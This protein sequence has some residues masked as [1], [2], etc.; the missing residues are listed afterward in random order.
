M[1]IARAL[2]A[3]RN[4][5]TSPPNVRPLAAGSA[6]EAYR[7]ARA[8]GVS[9]LV[10]AARSASSEP[11]GVLGSIDH[12]PQCSFWSSAPGL[13]NKLL[14]PY[15]GRTYPSDSYTTVMLCE[16]I[17]QNGW[18]RFGVLHSNDAYAN[19]YVE[20]LRTNAGAVGLSIEVQA[21]YEIQVE[22]SYS[23]AIQLIGNSR[24]NILVAVVWNQDLL[25]LAG[26]A[27]AQ[28]IWGMGFVWIATETVSPASTLQYM[29]D[30]GLDSNAASVLLDGV[31]VF[32]ASPQG[33]PG[34]ARFSNT[35]QA[36]NLTICSNPF[37]SASDSLLSTELWDVGA[38]AYD[39]VVAFAVSMANAQD[40]GDGIELSQ[41]FKKVSFRGASG[42][43]A[44]EALTGDRLVS[45][46]NYVLENW[47][48]SATGDVE[49]RIVS[50]ISRA[51]G[52]VNTTSVIRWMGGGHRKPVDITTIEECP[53]GKI[54]TYD[55]FGAP[56]CTACPIGEVE[57]QRKRCVEKVGK[58]GIIM[59][60]MN[61]DK[62]EVLSGVLWK[63]VTCAARLALTH[64]NLR[65]S[66]IVTGM[67]ALVGNLSH[68][69]GLMYDSGFSA[70]PAIVSYRQMKADGSMA[71]VG[72][73]RSAVSGAL[74]TQGKIDQI[75]QCSYWSSSPS[76]SD[77][78]LY[79][80]FGRTFPSDAI[81]TK[82]LPRLI[83][84]FGWANV[85]VLHVNDD[86]A[87]NYASGLRDNSR[88]SGVAVLASASFTQNDATTYAPACQSLKD[89]G[90]NVIVACAFD[91]DLVGLA[92]TCKQLGLWGE[93]FVWIV[94]DAA[95]AEGALSSGAEV[96]G[97]MRTEAASLLHGMQHFYAS[98]QGFDGYARFQADWKTRSAADCANPFFNASDV[99]ARSANPSEKAIYTNE[100]W[101]VAA[102]MYD[103]VVAFAAAMSRAIDPA[104]GVEVGRLFREVQF[105]GASGPVAFNSASDRERSSVN[106]VLA[107]WVADGDSLLAPLAGTITLDTTYVAVASFNM[108][109]AA[110]SPFTP[111]DRTTLDSCALGLVRDT[112]T[113]VPLC[114]PCP[115]S[116]VA[117]RGIDCVDKTV[118]IGMIMPVSNF[119][120]QQALGVNFFSLT[121]AARLAVEHV[122]S[123]DESVVPGLGQMVHN[124]S[125]IEA[126]YFDSGF[127]ENIAHRA[128]NEM[129]LRGGVDAMVGAARSVSSKAIATLGKLDQIPQ[130]SF[131]S[132]A[133]ELSDKLL[134][135]YFGRTYPSDEIT[136]YVICST[137]NK[138][139]WRRFSVLFD[140]GD[141]Y[142]KG[143]V[144]GLTR[145]AS[146]NSVDIRALAAYKAS[147]RAS[148][149]PAVAEV[150][151]SGV[152]IFMALM[153][154][155]SVLGI[156][157]EARKQ[158][159]LGSGYAWLLTDVS[160]SS[161]I[162]YA[163]SY[164]L[165]TAY[166]LSLLNGLL[167]FKFSPVGTA[168]YERYASSFQQQELSTCQTDL[169]NVTQYPSI[170][171]SGA[172]DVG[173]LVYDC[174]ISFAVAASRSLDPSDG[175]E[176]NRLFKSVEFNGASGS[177]KFDPTTADRHRSTANLIIL[178]WKLTSV[179][180]DARRRLGHRSL[181]GM[182]QLVE[183]HVMSTSL[184][185]ELTYTSNEI[186]WLGGAVGR[187]AAPVDIT[188]RPF[189][190]KT[191]EIVETTTGGVQICR[192]CMPGT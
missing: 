111:I 19:G 79:P 175:L 6:I 106:Y 151:A 171:S 82:V 49:I 76:L 90:V 69:E 101:D 87:N 119:A 152:N 3:R 110:D 60:H 143:L 163:A 187:H 36:A 89:T 113:G 132:S 81:T 141:A 55:E 34:Y 26:L 115:G 100:A 185:D 147:T 144:D 118:K 18:S 153:A 16:L 173:A 78:L 167:L 64:V 103:C 83:S 162:N 48:R 62:G 146:I 176:V 156:L 96:F 42:D 157:T 25:G 92:R 169:F 91:V 133:A 37:F 174:V 72:A 177:V 158:N 134:Y 85:G 53:K 179:S 54:R 8:A 154:D 71:M 128:Y 184:S 65:N 125:R 52:L 126:A 77:K 129:N 130:C 191:G 186:V 56:A 13:S 58:L 98:P 168:G 70:T 33:T 4:P 190:C 50:S 27:Q 45:S 183:E 138:L 28:G 93:G 32:L 84:S 1:F 164:N 20:G 97:L 140:E 21:S 67:D 14:Y 7:E 136:S 124:L 108:T 5:S 122:N 31:L 145:F 74:A 131:W 41:T 68:V 43:V 114:V 149:S 188:T 30:F 12:I 135:P 121:C 17:A 148:F 75:P 161:A 23:A 63:Q 109:W 59:P 165:S 127:D 94:A 123:R 2:R 181:S 51:S 105:D 46:A 120:T 38:Y 117:K 29:T 104:D 24:A 150:K 80:Y 57:V 180:Q 182:Y 66:T 142:S 155:H 139:G 40:P 73:A 11:L 9:A 10:G 178:N 47:Q 15:F 107:N 112:S 159:I 95:T 172:W 61:A 35:M 166:A 44:F 88:D 39:C 137:I 99:P 86:Y 189:R 160:T 192:A 102:Y 22:S 116:K 170:F